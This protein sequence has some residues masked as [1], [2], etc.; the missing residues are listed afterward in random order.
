VF[1]ALQP[2]SVLQ[3]RGVEDGNVRGNAVGRGDVLVDAAFTPDT[4]WLVTASYDRTVRMWD[5]GSVGCVWTSRRMS[6]PVLSI[7]F[8]RDGASLA[9]MA[10]S[11]VLTLWETFGDAIPDDERRLARERRGLRGLPAL[12]WVRGLGGGVSPSAMRFI[13]P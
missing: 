7:A 10:S 13:Y 4:E 8:S 2:I 1:F 9:T 5:T 11:G 6:D 12:R 3:V